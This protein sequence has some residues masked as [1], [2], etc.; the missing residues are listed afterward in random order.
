VGFNMNRRFR[1]TCRLHLQGRRNNANEKKCK[2]DANRQTTLLPWR[3][4]RHVPPKRRFILNP[5]GATSQNTAFFK[6]TAVKPSHSVFSPRAGSSETL[7]R[8]YQRVHAAACR[9]GGRS[10]VVPGNTG[11]LHS[12]L[13]SICSLRPQ[14]LLN[15]SRF[16]RTQAEVERHL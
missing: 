7:G 2:T 9:G 5:H 16:K 1:G 4:R 8:V 13:P 12:C 3:W 11:P 15:S 14:R 10:L 6:V